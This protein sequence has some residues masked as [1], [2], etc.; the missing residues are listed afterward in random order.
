[1]TRGLARFVPTGHIYSFGILGLL[2]LVACVTDEISEDEQAPIDETTA[3][4]PEGNAP[5]LP[6]DDIELQSKLGALDQLIAEEEV[7]V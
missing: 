1:M 6:A 7:Q 4:D 3:E 2:S 5:R